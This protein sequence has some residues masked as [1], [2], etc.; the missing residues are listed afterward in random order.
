MAKRR[1]PE[2]FAQ[3]WAAGVRQ[4]RRT[5]F[6]ELRDA[7]TERLRALPPGLIRKVWIE[8]AESDPEAALALSS[9]LREV[10]P[11]S[12]PDEALV[13]A[14]RKA[15]WRSLPDA[16]LLIPYLPASLRDAAAEELIEMWREGEKRSYPVLRELPTPLLPKIPEQ[17]RRASWLAFVRSRA[18]EAFEALR[19]MPDEIARC[20]SA[21]DVLEA[22][23]G[24]ITGHPQ[25]VQPGAL[26]R[27]PE[28]FHSTGLAEVVGRA[29][30]ALA[31]REDIAPSSTLHSLSDLGELHP[32]LRSKVSPAA[33]AALWRRL[34][35]TSSR[36]CLELLAILPAELLADL[37]PVEAEL[38]WKNGIR[39]DHAIG[40]LTYIAHMPARLRS[41]IEPEQLR[42]LMRRLIETPRSTRLIGVLGAMPADLRAMIGPALEREAI[43]RIDAA[44][45]HRWLDVVAGDFMSSNE[46]ERE[47]KAKE[48]ADKGLLGTA[49]EI[50]AESDGGG[51]LDWYATRRAPFQP[52]IPRDC[53]RYAWRRWLQR[54]FTAVSV[55]HALAWIGHE[56][57]AQTPPAAPL[58]QGAETAVEPKPGS[59]SPAPEWVRGIDVK[60]EVEE[61]IREAL[62]DDLMQGL[63]LR[64]A[65]PAPL[66]PAIEPEVLKQ[67]WVQMLRE[68]RFQDADQLWTE[69]AG[70]FQHLVAPSDIASLLESGSQEVRLRVIGL[71]AQVLGPKAAGFLP[72]GVR[73]TGG[74]GGGDVAPAAPVR[75]MPRGR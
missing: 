64:A 11:G 10:L 27:L 51:A 2:E 74:L 50:W 43:R 52:L 1:T 24:A 35:A 12:V 15:S 62:L 31:E 40:P 56:A 44:D 14:W 72:N 34:V 18:V 49:F 25:K 38:V 3:D 19:I 13:A 47:E 66:R 22:A 8:R 30:A 41:W 17:E 63:K 45:I 9:R 26:L 5:A 37:H 33:V 73:A 55:E 21:D 32:A 48:Y 57:K 53:V 68:E 71:T 60:A 7:S 54:D 6:R 16:A 23:R 65:L 36:Q 59:A 4:G 61:A 46:T 67:G 70:A 20:I 69:D 39:M 29:Y 58:G 75:K 28:R 42:E